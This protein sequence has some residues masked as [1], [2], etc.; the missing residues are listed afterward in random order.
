[1]SEFPYKA[2]VLT[3]SFALK[4]V[5][6][7]REHWWASKYRETGGGKAYRVDGLYPTKSAAIRAGRELVEKRRQDLA[8]RQQRIDR[9]SAALDK[10]EGV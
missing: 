7:V 3:P 9:L 2:W 8:K 1:M 10:A 5:T 6:I 4:E